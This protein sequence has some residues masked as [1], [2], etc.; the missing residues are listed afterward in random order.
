MKIP[1]NLIQKFNTN[2]INKELEKIKI[3]DEEWVK[4]ILWKLYWKIIQEMQKKHIKNTSGFDKKLS[5][6]ETAVKRI[7]MNAEVMM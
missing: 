5:S 7:R 3:F 4:D 2:G 1:F 6:L